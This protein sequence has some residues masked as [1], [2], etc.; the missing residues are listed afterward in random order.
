MD[1]NLPGTLFIEFSRQEYW[2]RLLFPTPG[3]LPDWGIEPESPALAD[4]FFITSATQEALYD[5]AILLLD[6]FTQEKWKHA[7]T[8]ACTQ[9]FHPNSQT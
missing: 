7:H 6:N 8:V 2:S 3:D 9:I 5:L 4:A 1:Y